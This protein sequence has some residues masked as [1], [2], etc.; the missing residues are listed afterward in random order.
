M[1]SSFLVGLAL[2]MIQTVTAR[3][4]A[5]TPPS[6]TRWALDAGY[7]FRLWDTK[8]TTEE[9]SDY[10]EKARFGWVLGGDVA[11]FPW[12]H[13]GLGISY[14]RF[15]SETS[16]SDIGFGDGS[17]GESTDI[18][19]IEF[20]GPSLYL[21]HDFERVTGILQLGGGVIYYDNQHQAEDFP[22]V[23]QSVAPGFHAILSADYRIL[24]KLAV[25]L[26]ARFLYGVLD[27]ISYNG[28][29]VP[30]PPISLTRVDL[31]AGL[32]FYP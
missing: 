27:E 8:S 13:V 31:A 9:R 7:G 22:G 12:R 25:G 3:E 17:R 1:Q 24:P 30:I 10:E 2:L 15:M 4:V 28:I 16:T 23:L 32:R 5:L 20:V 26:S 18:Y 11:V 14:Y 19:L 6:P 29:E 21:K